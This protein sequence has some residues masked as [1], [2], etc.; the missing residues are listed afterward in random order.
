MKFSK[1]SIKVFWSYYV[2][3]WNFSF[4]PPPRV[5]WRT[6]KISWGLLLVETLCQISMKSVKKPWEISVKCLKKNPF[7]TVQGNK[8]FHHTPVYTLP[9]MRCFWRPMSVEDLISWRNMDTEDIWLQDTR[10]EAYIL[11]TELSETRTFHCQATNWLV[12]PQLNKQKTPYV[13]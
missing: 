11:I 3:T 12:K 8:I 13:S 4:P 10:T 1:W 2:K 7:H 9:S 5:C 6:D